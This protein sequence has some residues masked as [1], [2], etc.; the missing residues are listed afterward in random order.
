MR[1]Q[2]HPLS[3]MLD[4]L[5]STILN[6][7][8]TLACNCEHKTLFCRLFFTTNEPTIYHYL[9]HILNLLIPHMNWLFI[10]YAAILV[11]PWMKSFCT[12]KSFATISLFLRLGLS[13]LLII[14]FGNLSQ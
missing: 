6:Q 10:I 7:T 1:N 3:L 4:S 11:Q 2:V 9:Y 13:W 8:L 12:P 5:L 14:S